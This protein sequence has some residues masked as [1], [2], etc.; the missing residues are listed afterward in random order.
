MSDVR[1]YKRHPT[2]YLID[3]QRLLQEASEFIFKNR[4]KIKK[5][6]I[7]DDIKKKDP[8][9]AAKVMDLIVFESED[10]NNQQDE[11]LASASEGLE[12]SEGE[13]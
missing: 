4:G 12:E 9:V 3:N 1:E 8:T 2:A 11:E 6:D 10:S 7:W 5:C 13:G